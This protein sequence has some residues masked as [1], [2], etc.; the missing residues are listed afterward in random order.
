MT[1]RTRP[2]F[3][4]SLLQQENLCQ[5]KSCNLQVSATVRASGPLALRLWQAHLPCLSNSFFAVEH[6]DSALLSWADLPRL[7]S[8]PICW[9]CC[10]LNLPVWVHRS[11]FK[12]RQVL[13]F[14]KR[15]LHHA[16][17]GAYRNCL[18][19]LA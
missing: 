16:L 7:C 15:R 18:H 13:T 4:L 10:T 5:W 1:A 17:R 11:G 19:A 2:F 12:P 9:I 14:T 8:W 3:F 6:G